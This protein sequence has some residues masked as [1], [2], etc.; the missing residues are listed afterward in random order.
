M[1]KTIGRICLATMA[2]LLLV[3]WGNVGHYKINY[4]SSSFL[5]QEMVTFKTWSLQMAQHASDADTRKNTDHSEGKKH[6][7]DIDNYPGFGQSHKIIENY[8]SAIRVYGQDFVL[9]NG[10]LPWS[11]YK[12]YK[13]LVN[14]MK[15]QN[16][17]SAMLIAADLGHYV[18]DGHMPLHITN[19]YDG[20]ETNQKGVH[21]RYESKM[22]ETFIQ[23]ITYDSTAIAPVANVQLF[24][25]NY[26]YHNYIY[27]DSLLQADKHA[28]EAAGNSYSDVYYTNLWKNT[29]SFTVPLFNNASKSLAQLIYTAWIEAGKPKI[30]ARMAYQAKL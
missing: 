1:K 22:I 29:K 25:F 28:F 30:A 19:N 14:D 11:T 9:K 20:V 2:C 21:S 23:E 24:I 12:A 8:D 6:Y 18:A 13:T 15:V 17:D 26:L 4:T 27:K 16:W 10:T 7:I 5:P 3:N